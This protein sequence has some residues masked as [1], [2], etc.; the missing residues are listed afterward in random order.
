MDETTMSSEARRQMHT[1]A[2]LIDANVRRLIDGDIADVDELRTAEQLLSRARSIIPARAPEPL[3]AA[4][5]DARVAA[6]QAARKAPVE[7]P[8]MM[9]TVSAINL[10]LA[11]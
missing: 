6:W 3:I 2:L 7:V 11:S 1:A 5:N 9:R 4:I 8:P 10:L